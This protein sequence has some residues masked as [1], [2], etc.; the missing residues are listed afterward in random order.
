MRNHLDG[1][2]Y[3]LKK[4]RIRS[5][6]KMMTR[7]TREVELLSQMNHENVVRWVWLYKLKCLLGTALKA[8]GS[9]CTVVVHPKQGS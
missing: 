1:R 7:I 5:D 4:I 9:T 3:A 8:T 6:S 2:L